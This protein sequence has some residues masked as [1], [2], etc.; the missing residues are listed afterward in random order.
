MLLGLLS[1]TLLA[2]PQQL[3]AAEPD[4]DSAGFA[5]KQASV[6]LVNGVYQVDARLQYRLDGKPREALENGVPLV[7]EVALKVQR[8]RAYLW[9]ET[10]AE[11]LMQHKLNYRGLTQQYQLEDLNTGE[12]ESFTSLGAAL[13]FLRQL[14]AFPLIDESLLQA[15]GSYLLSIRTNL[16]IESLPTPL[17]ALAY[18][19][20]DWYL[21]SAWYTVPLR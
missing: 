9:N 12:K 13:N 6:S 21:S 20:P 17:R 8:V 19:T 15:D 3:W 14:H 5:V 18:V 1:A 10:I 16:D 2:L 11:V 4:D 7:L